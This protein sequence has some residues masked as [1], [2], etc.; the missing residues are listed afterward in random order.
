MSPPG[1]IRSI[2]CALQELTVEALSLA[3]LSLR[4]HTTL[5]AENLFIRKQL[6]F[7]QE[8]GI[9]GRRLTNWARLWLVFWSRS[10]KWSSALLVVNPETLVSWHRKAFR[11]LWKR[12]SRPGKRRIPLELR[13]LIVRMVREN[14]TWGEERIANELWL[15]LGTRVSPRTVRVHWPGKGPS[16]DQHSQSWNTFVRNH[17]QAL[18][19]CD[20]MIAV[21]ARFN[22]LYIFVVMEIGSRRVLH[23]N[24]TRHP[25]A[26]LFCDR[27]RLERK[28]T[29]RTFT[30]S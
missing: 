4:S 10:N 13:R 30:K 24:T 5:I 14:P 19:A 8:R 23:C 1:L 17:A 7:Y 27:R 2:P 11:L 12:K 28:P 18:L 20:F 16:T 9:R 26:S 15:K 25:T 3:R 6:A 29:E 21:T 22:V